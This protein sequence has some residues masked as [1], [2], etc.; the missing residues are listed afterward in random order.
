MGVPIGSL[1]EVTAPLTSDDLVIET[2]GGTRRT[3]R[4]NLQLRLSELSALVASNLNPLASEN[5]T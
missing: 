2:A 1:T 3:S 5:Q 4:E